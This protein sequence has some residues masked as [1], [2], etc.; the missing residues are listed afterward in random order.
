MDIYCIVVL[1]TQDL[2]W[3]AMHIRESNFFFV[4]YF[5]WPKL[6]DACVFVD[7]GMLY[8]WEWDTLCPDVAV[9]PTMRRWLAKVR[10][11]KFFECPLMRLVNYLLEALI[12]MWRPVEEA[13]DVKGHILSLNG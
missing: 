10:L 1:S 4:F 6:T 7:V 13:F 5:K 3:E 11:L 9:R 12:E 2:F 8:L